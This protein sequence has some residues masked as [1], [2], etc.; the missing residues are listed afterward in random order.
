MKSPL[1]FAA[2]ALTGAA[3]M[4]LPTA[5]A[6]WRALHPGHTAPGPSRARTSNEFGFTTNGPMDRVAPLFGADKERVWSP[7]WDPQFLYPSPAADA[8]GM[9]FQ[10]AHGPISVPWINTEFDLEN[11]RVQYAYVIPEKLVTL[12]TIRMTPE[13]ERTRVAVRY[14]QTAL[15]AEGDEH[16][17][18]MAAQRANAGP[19]WEKMINDYLAAQRQ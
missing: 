12:I 11:G 9:V 10:V 19:E 18:R 6:H 7:G 3:L 2:G 14:D 15:S 5:A 13:G 1:L 17:R 4:F 16:V 8:P